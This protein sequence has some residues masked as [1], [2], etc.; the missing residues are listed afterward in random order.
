[1]LKAS[2]LIAWLAQRA[3]DEVY[4]CGDEL[5][6]DDTDTIHVGDADEYDDEEVCDG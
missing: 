6:C 3:D 1:M 2:E 5:C 4:I